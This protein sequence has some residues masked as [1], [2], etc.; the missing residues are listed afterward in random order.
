MRDY[1]MG[2]YVD[3]YGFYITLEDELTYEL[4]SLVERVE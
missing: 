2:K 1:F 3:L 4:N